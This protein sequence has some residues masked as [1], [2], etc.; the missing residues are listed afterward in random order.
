MGLDA[1]ALQLLDDVAP[2][3]AALQGERHLAAAGEPLQPLA[4]PQPIRRRDPSP[5]H[6]AGVE[7]DIVE[8]QLRAMNIDPTHDRHD[9]LPSLEHAGRDGGRHITILVI[10]PRAT[11]VSDS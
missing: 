2:P 6:L 8:R 9:D 1:G 11:V 5:E 4:Q 10:R 7:I 3:R